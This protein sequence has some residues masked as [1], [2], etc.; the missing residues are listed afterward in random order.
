MSTR[1]AEL[2]SRISTDWSLKM[3]PKAD[4]H[5]ELRTQA[6]MALRHVIE[7][8]QALETALDVGEVIVERLNQLEFDL[9]GL[10]GDV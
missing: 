1:A 8:H 4:P 6:V 9:T 5:D 2:L 3:E 7:A 10:P